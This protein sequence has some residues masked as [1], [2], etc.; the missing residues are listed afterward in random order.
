MYS[1]PL[2]T[3]FTKNV[4]DIGIREDYLRYVTRC[5]WMSL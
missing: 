1:I 5:K 2:T 4:P 3:P